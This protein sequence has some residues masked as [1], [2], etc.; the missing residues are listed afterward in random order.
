MQADILSLNMMPP[1]L[2]QFIVHDV[3]LT[4]LVVKAGAFGSIEEVDMYGTRVVAKKL[5]PQF[6]S[7]HQ[8]P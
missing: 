8:V 6:G 4:G 5:N 3:V 1:D 7:I 2:E